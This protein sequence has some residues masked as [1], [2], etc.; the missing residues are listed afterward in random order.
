MS[1]QDTIKETISGREVKEYTITNKNNLSI[2]L[3]EYRVAIVSVYTSNKNG[4]F[5]NIVLNFN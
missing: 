5:H 4:E 3:M 1:I 2:F